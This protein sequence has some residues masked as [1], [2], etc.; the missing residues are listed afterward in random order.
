VTTTYSGYTPNDPG[1][2]SADM[3][4]FD[5]YNELYMS[6]TQGI[7]FTFEDGQMP[8][9]G[10]LQGYVGPYC[11]AYVGQSGTSVSPG[12]ISPTPSLSDSF[13]DTTSTLSPS[14]PD[15]LWAALQTGQHLIPVT[16]TGAT[17]TVSESSVLDL[18]CPLGFAPTDALEM[19]V[20]D[21]AA[22]DIPWFTLYMSGSPNVGACT[23][24]WD[25]STPC[26]L[27]ASATYTNYASSY[28]SAVETYP[29]TLN[30]YDTQQ[31]LLYTYGTMTNV[32]AAITAGSTGLTSFTWN[33]TNSAGVV[34]PPGIYLYQWT[35]G[36]GGG[37][38]GDSN[39][40]PNISIS[41]PSQYAT[42]VS[43]NGTNAVYAVSYSMASSI[44]PPEPA[45]GA[46]LVYDPNQ[47]LI[48]TTPVSAAPGAYTT[49]VTIPSP[50]VEG[51]YTFLVT[52]TDLGDYKCT[53]YEPQHALPHNNSHMRAESI[54]YA[55]PNTNVLETQYWE[56]DAQDWATQMTSIGYQNVAYH[57]TNQ[58]D[59]WY[60]GPYI[61]QMRGPLQYVAS[62]GKRPLR[63][64]MFTGHGN[65]DGNAILLGGPKGEHESAGSQYFLVSTTP[66]LN[67]GATDPTNLNQQDCLVAD[68]ITAGPGGSLPFANLDLVMLCGCY[69]AFEVGL[70]NEFRTG[71]AG[72]V[73]SVGNASQDMNSESIW[74]YDTTPPWPPDMPNGGFLQLL[75]KN[76]IKAATNLTNEGYDALLLDD[77]S[78]ALKVVNDS[79]T[80]PNEHVQLT[81]SVP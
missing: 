40:S 61:S 5:G 24:T 18:Q 80:G 22:L 26:Q 72:C 73:V 32:P 20:E 38:F 57:T 54:A 75:A 71:G 17:T 47:N 30:I 27:S 53:V 68:T 33:G 41:A 37:Q 13:G 8:A 16:L 63:T 62:N 29:I 81:P 44:T 3:S 50:T 59:T 66:Y 2:G 15:L 9:F 76:Q 14:P 51:T 10:P 45:S 48:D 64:V 52:A 65:S 55:W 1:F 79:C 78:F 19:G 77:P 39:I 12:Q 35:L 25:G 70:A 11:Y 60:G 42:L 56:D 6:D 34:E 46:I 69:Q 67:S 49:N 23:M 58:Y 31:N 43:D 21:E 7:E 36:S 4:P 74:L 28:A